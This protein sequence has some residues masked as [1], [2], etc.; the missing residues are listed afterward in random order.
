MSIP[1][2]RNGPVC[3]ACTRSV[4]G[5][6]RH[7]P[8]PYLCGLV[9]V[10][11]SA[12]DRFAEGHGFPANEKWFDP[13]VRN[14]EPNGLPLGRNIANAL[15][16]KPHPTPFPGVLP[17][18]AGSAIFTPYS[19]HHVSTT[20][21]HRKCLPASSVVLQTLGGRIKS[22]VCIEN[23]PSIVGENLLTE[24]EI[25]RSWQKLFREGSLC[26]DTFTRAEALLEELRAESPLRHRLEGELEELRKMSGSATAG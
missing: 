16:Q 13:L 19:T 10:P 18:V 23:H 26:E 15:R 21:A 8:G 6:L 1:R 5:H 12:A 14:D 7:G 25:S 20:S 24:Q 3:L 11:D 22:R 9:I 4:G 17:H 2:S